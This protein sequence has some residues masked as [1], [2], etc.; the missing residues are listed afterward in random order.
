MLPDRIEFVASLPLNSSKKLDEARLLSEAGLQP[1][2]RNS[3][4]S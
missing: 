4:Q 3:T 1:F 2:R